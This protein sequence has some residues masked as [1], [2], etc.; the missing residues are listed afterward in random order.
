M[1]EEARAHR[2]VVVAG[3]TGALGRAVTSELVTH[4]FEVLP[5]G[6]REEAVSA[7]AR[8]LGCARWAVAELG[9]GSTQLEGALARLAPFDAVVDVVG[10]FTAGPLLHETDAA[11]F[12][13][14]FELN[15]FSAYELARAALPHLLARGGGALVF[16][17]ARAALEPFAG[18]SA[19][20]ISKAA[21]HALV[22]ALDADYRRRG[23]RANAI[24]PGVI[25]TPANR[26]ANPDADR[27]DWVDPRDIARVVRF[28]VS[29][30]ST[31]IAG[32]LVPVWAPA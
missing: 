27:S 30:D 32:Q 15:F 31:P 12:R 1:S 14:L 18:A 2:A 24:V 4:G 9:N 26:R 22:R 17:G 7:L 6:R 29:D 28:L 25:D 20:V 16:T 13:A 5:L 21:L 10:G 3:A 23:V 8:E 19:Y 11:D